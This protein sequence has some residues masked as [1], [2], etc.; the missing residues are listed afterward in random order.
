MTTLS[1][2]D[3]A[4]RRIR[5]ARK[6][7]EWRVKDLADAC[8][9][10]DKPDITAAVITNLETRRRPGREITA[11]ELLA[12][13]WVLKVPPLQLLCPLDGNERLEVVPGEE[14]DPVEAAAWL[15]D[16]DVAL[17]AMSRAGNTDSGGTERALRYRGSALTVIRQIRA[18][19]RRMQVHDKLAGGGEEEKRV[20]YLNSVGQLALRLAH[21]GA[22]LEALGY[23]PP[24]LPDAVAEIL[25]RRGLPATVAGWEARGAPDDDEE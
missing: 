23:A 9:K 1:A 2:S 15:A 17:A 6:K 14:K 12:L 16:D 20:F 10:A 5:E 25:A 11:E 21:L 7:R 3:I 8:K 22:S 4:A 18:A 19:E 24:P 13:A